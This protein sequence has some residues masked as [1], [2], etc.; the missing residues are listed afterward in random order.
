[1]TRGCRTSL[2]T[3][4]R[5]SEWH[6]RHAGYTRGSGNL[7]FEPFV[8]EDKGPV[9]TYGARQGLQSG[10]GVGKFNP[11]KKGGGYYFF[12]SGGWGHKMGKSRVCN[13]M[14]PPSKQGKTFV[15]LF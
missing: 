15:P 2:E 11:Y 5:E 13:F 12:S 6:Q 3:E 4:T 1:M 14:R 8:E 10:R 7:Y 9:I